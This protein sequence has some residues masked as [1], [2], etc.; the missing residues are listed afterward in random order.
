MLFATLTAWGRALELDVKAV[1]SNTG[2]VDRIESKG[3]T[4]D[5][6]DLA[7]LGV[8][9]TVGQL[10]SPW[11]RAWDGH[12]VVDLAVGRLED[13]HGSP[14]MSFS[15]VATSEPGGALSASDDAGS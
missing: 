8:D 3:L 13:R 4:T 9:S 1:L 10:S 12:E 15:S 2:L 6:F 11:A 7:N 14:R 5:G